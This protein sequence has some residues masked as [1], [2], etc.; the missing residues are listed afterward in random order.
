ME[1]LF[2]AHDLASEPLAMFEVHIPKKID[3]YRHIQ[4][5]L[6]TLF[7]MYKVVDVPGVVNKM[8]QANDN[9]MSV[10]IT[11]SL[12]QLS[13]M[14]QGYSIYEVDGRFLVEGK[15]VDERILV[16]RFYIRGWTTEFSLPDIETAIQVLIG[17]RL[18]ELMPNEKEIWIV[19]HQYQVLHCFR[20][21]NVPI[22]P[23]EDPEP[24]VE[25]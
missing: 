1:S 10:K 11:K 16:V 14:F 3:Y 15:P 22:V 23:P 5:V 8:V 12:I 4:D 6:E 19:Q 20:G 2:G 7:D 24:R 17:D 21:K 18:A 13:K 9:Y 25:V